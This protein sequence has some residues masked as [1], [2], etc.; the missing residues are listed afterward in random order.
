MNSI[1]NIFWDSLEKTVKYYRRSDKNIVLNI[2]KK[3][4][5][6]K[7]V[8][9]RYYD[10]KDCYMTKETDNIKNA[11][12]EDKV[13]LDRH[14]VAAIFIVSAIENNL[15]KYSKEIDK[16]KFIGCEMFITEVAWSWMVDKL[17]DSLK[18]T[19]KETPH[20]DNLFMPK[21]FACPT[22]YFD[23][24]CRELFYANEANKLFEL[25]IAEKLF[26]IEYITLLKNNI[27]PDILCEY[28]TD[29]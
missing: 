15:I 25:D 3:E 5:F 26:L 20:I 29:K 28:E 21:A 8:K 23:I 9:K 6:Y 2:E 1:I 24:F 7:D 16:S 14:K 27:N 18:K 22:P 13:Y 10:L 4:D 11:N 19:N 17:N 12:N